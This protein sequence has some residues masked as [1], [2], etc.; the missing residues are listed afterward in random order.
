MGA[1][2][3]AKTFL[4]TD[5]EGSTRSW[6]RHGDVM[7]DL[8]QR[9]NALLDEA[10]ERY[11][12]RVFSNMGD[13]VAAAFDDPA[14]GV[15]A[16]VA[17]Q[18]AI[19]ASDWAP[20][21]ELRVRMGV[22]RGDVT[23]KR[24]DYF[25]PPLNRCSRMMSAAHGGQ[26]LASEAVVEAIHGELPSGT[27]VRDLGEHR[28][29]DLARAEHI[30]QVEADDLPTNF[31]PIRS[32]AVYQQNLPVQISS[33]VGRERDVEA[34]SRL[35]LEH[36][37]VTLRGPGGGGK[38][39]LAFQVAA[40]VLDRYSDGLYVVDL[41]PLRGPEAVAR[42]VAQAVGGLDLLV[43]AG[44][45]LDST[46][47]NE[48][49]LAR[50]AELLTHKNVLLLMDNC[51]HLVAACARLADSLLRAVPTLV[52][53]ATSRERL[54]VAGEQLFQVGTME[55]PDPGAGLEEAR[56]STA[57][58][59]FV[60]RARAAQPSFDLT[61]ANAR[62]VVAICK[63]VDGLPLA[64]ELAAARTRMMTPQQIYERLDSSFRLLT[65]GDRAGLD[66]HQTINATL[67]WSHDL[68]ADDER[69]LLRRLGVFRGTA[70][71]AQ[72]EEVCG[73]GALPVGQVC[74]LL[75][76]LVDK[77]LV[78]TDD[79]DVTVRY[80]LLE[81][82]R[83]FAQAQLAE[84][85]EVEEIRDRHAAAYFRL[86]ELRRP[87]E[88][89]SGIRS[90]EPEV[91]NLRAGFDWWRT[92]GRQ[93]DALE[94]ATLLW[95]FWSETGHLDEGLR[96][97]DVTLNAAEPG[98]DLEARAR[99]AWS[100]LASQQGDFRGGL[101]AVDRAITLSRRAT[102]TTMTLPWAL[103]RRGQLLLDQGRIEESRGPLAEGAA[104]FESLS[105]P[106]GRAWCLLELYRGRV[107]AG[108]AL[109]VRPELENLFR[110][111]RRLG[112]PIVAGYVGTIHGLALALTGDLIAGRAAVDYGIDVLDEVDCR[113]T[114]PIALLLA[115]VVDELAG[116]LSSSAARIQRAL[117][118]CRLSGA[119][120]TAITGI[121]WAARILGRLGR[122]DQSTILTG[123]AHG[124][125]TDFAILSPAL[126][127]QLDA[128]VRTEVS[129]AL[130]AAHARAHQIG[131]GL[132]LVEA[133][134]LA[135]AELASNSGPEPSS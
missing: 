13:G 114:E 118:T 116:D 45:S 108:E 19:K 97:L 89:M 115:A 111:A 130:G 77:S 2:H 62:A 4:F 105:H 120:Y 17:A 39:R 100:F 34:V 58:Q 14:R 29:R 124:L 85:G 28:L 79:G 16:A 10:V 99:S 82:V 127:D 121:D 52:V 128:P 63:R 54:G 36:R 68:L 26:V 96:W 86:A 117:R 80:R 23:L 70:D 15:E 78:V 11:G 6:E 21:P 7:A 113:F 66:R 87:V 65:S 102:P 98:E 106:Y 71:L 69:I 81:V 46:A 84:R 131:T 125:R 83:D 38:T 55:M 75:G 12:G 95:R 59:L 35:L 48:V 104:T 110:S 9:H 119:V 5:V 132:S 94:L 73:F 33:F 25:G 40:E 76:Q 72:I 129:G 41:A 42:A 123:A 126:A 51:E 47:D 20:L 134:D 64:L 44:T 91:D 27:R 24:D 49:E 43:G 50:V 101:I 90:L 8:I 135:V 109:E 88:T 18:R 3:S 60:E 22:H 122:Y 37:L 67:A 74:D 61:P 107:L 133:A 56:T 53:L 112:E 1:E 32:L 57:V 31:P 92:R 103:F 30:Y 93:R